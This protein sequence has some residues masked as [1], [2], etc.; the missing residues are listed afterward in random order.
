M[1]SRLA[2]P[3]LERANT[4]ARNRLGDFKAFIQRAEQ[5]SVERAKAAD[6]I[7]RGSP[8]QTMACVFGVGVLIGILAG[9]K[10]KS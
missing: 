9:R 8:Y 7:V 5:Q 1:E 2:T 4:T 3:V 10:W 6:R